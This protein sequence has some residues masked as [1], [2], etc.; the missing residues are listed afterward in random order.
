MT[1]IIF[2]TRVEG[3]IVSLNESISTM[4]KLAD[5]K[6]RSTEDLSY[7]SERLREEKLKQTNIVEKK[8]AEIK[9]LNGTEKVLFLH[10]RCF[11]HVERKIQTTQ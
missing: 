11:K 8:D 2:L 1:R 3:E 6:T 10:F 7:E 4:K 9:E 5:Q